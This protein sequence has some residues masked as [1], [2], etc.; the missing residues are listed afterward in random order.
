MRV[1]TLIV[2][3]LLIVVGIVGYAGQDPAQ[4]KVSPTALIPAI[5]G[6][7]IGVCG[8]L[9]FSDKLRKHAMHLASVVGL[10]GVF[11]GV[12]PLQRQAKTIREDAEKAGAPISMSEAWSKVDPLKPSAVS[13]VLTSLIC[14]VFVGLCVKSFIDA[15]KARAKQAQ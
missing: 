4:G 13:G 2:A 11:G 9:S 5:I 12:M 10:I 7:V 15:R 6:A 14:L 1:P 8:L 3:V